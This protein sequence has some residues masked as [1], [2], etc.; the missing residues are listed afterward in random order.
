[1]FIAD[2]LRFEW[3]RLSAERPSPLAV[4][5]RGWDDATPP[6][7][8]SAA[9]SDML[10]SMDLVVVTEEPAPIATSA[11]AIAAGE[12]ALDD[13]GPHAPTGRSN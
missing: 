4:D 1:M 2:P 3:E 12:T 5:L 11:G 10:T 8:V 7:F 6:P 9:I 13:L